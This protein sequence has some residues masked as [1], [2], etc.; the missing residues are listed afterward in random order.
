MLGLPIR[1]AWPRVTQGAQAP[2]SGNG[3][4]L[5]NYTVGGFTVTRAA[6]RCAPSTENLLCA[7]AEAPSIRNESS[8]RLP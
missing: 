4:E 1:P 2:A 5:E 8:A 3:S 6:D 7:E